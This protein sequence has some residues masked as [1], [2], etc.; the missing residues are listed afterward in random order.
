MH[1]HP[2]PA[3]LVALTPLWTG[4]RFESGRPRV[5]DGVLDRLRTATTEQAWSVL[6][7][8]GYHRQFAGGWLQTHPG[9]PL[10]GRAVTSSFLPH[11][12]DFDS[13][14]VEQGA[15]E[16][17]TAGDRQ[18]TWIIESLVEGDVMVTD[19]FGK[20]E[21]GTVIGDNLGTAIAARTR[22]G[23][24][25]D[26][27]IRDMAGLVELPGVNFFCRG[28]HPTAIV[29]VTLAGI[30][31]PIRIDAVTVLPGDVVLG[32][33]TG[34]TFIPAHLAEEVADVAEDVAVRDVF[35]KQRLSE[36]VYSSAEIDVQD[37]APGIES[38]FQAW[39]G[40]R[41]R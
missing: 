32:T 16:G 15:S 29:D 3:W 39:R 14:V 12:P 38:D 1:V 35:G 40:D 9:R 22:A 10:V 19:I 5:A 4:E 13:V 20:V 41:N 11:R 30:N 18:N 33:D 21:D 8:H 26:G 7:K 27:G 23:A 36:R 31:T 34:V 25:I 6:R 24:V 17:N 28:A 37:W 2:D